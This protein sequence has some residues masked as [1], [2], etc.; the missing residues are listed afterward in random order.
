MNVEFLA[1]SFIPFIVV[2]GT[3]FFNNILKPYK[4]L[5]DPTGEFNSGINF[6]I[7]IWFGLVCDVLFLIK[8]V[9]SLYIDNVKLFIISQFPNYFNI[10]STVLYWYILSFIVIY[11]L[12][13]SIYYKYSKE[14]PK[15][16]NTFYK[17]SPKQLKNYILL[18]NGLPIILLLISIVFYL[19]STYLVYKLENSIDKTLIFVIVICYSFIWIVLMGIIDRIGSLLRIKITRTVLIDNCEIV[20]PKVSSHTGCYTKEIVKTKVIEDNR[21]T[22]FDELFLISKK[23]HI[24]GYLVHSDNDKHIIIADGYEIAVN[25]HWILYQYELE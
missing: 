25:R 13:A 8:T 6:L 24:D 14:Y 7:V 23:P 16:I 19:L 5:N 9:I 20:L 1:L 18:N 22:P 12:C 3:S 15:L 21:N 10:Y 2:F 11:G 17:M 4:L